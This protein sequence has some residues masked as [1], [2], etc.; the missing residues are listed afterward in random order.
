MRQGT[1]YKIQGYA[2]V[3]FTVAAAL[4][5]KLLYE[6]TFFEIVAFVK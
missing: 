4:L 1:R 2:I 5:M 6:I 3:V